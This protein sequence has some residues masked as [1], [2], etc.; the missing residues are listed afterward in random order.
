MPARYVGIRDSMMEKGLSKDEA[1]E[2]AAK[3]YN[4]T[5]RHDEP[6]LTADYDRKHPVKKQL[7]SKKKK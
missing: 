1:Q 7:T 5:R 2:R 3:I 4:S 6:A